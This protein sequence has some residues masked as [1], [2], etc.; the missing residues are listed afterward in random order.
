MEPQ[1]QCGFQLSEAFPTR[2]HAHVHTENI[3]LHNQFN[4]ERLVPGCLQA[5]LLPR[6]EAHHRQQYPSIPPLSVEDGFSNSAP[7]VSPMAVYGQK[8]PLQPSCFAL[9][10]CILQSKPESK[11]NTHTLLSRAICCHGKKWSHLLN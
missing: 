8:N 4:L 10:F 6:A 7:K 2:T 9:F 11:F 5:A 3:P 1:Q